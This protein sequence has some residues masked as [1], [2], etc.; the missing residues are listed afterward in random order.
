MVASLYARCEK[1]RH[2][3]RSHSSGSCAAKAGER[4]CRCNGLVIT[5]PEPESDVNDA[6]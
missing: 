4:R 6:E 2:T 3:T 1:C 5:P